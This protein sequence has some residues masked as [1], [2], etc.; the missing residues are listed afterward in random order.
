[1]VNPDNV[2]RPSP[3]PRD[4]RLAELETQ[5]RQREALIEQLQQR[6]A[7]LEQRL[8]EMERAA[9]RQATPFARK[10]RKENPKR[11]GRKAG[12]GRFTAR[13]RPTPDQVTE[14]K[15]QPLEACPRCGDPLTDRKEHEQFVVDIPE[16]QP[17]V[18]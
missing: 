5:L 10:R 2:L 6:L 15:E 8:A 17:R 9:K 7:E 16:V 3:D 4:V 18:T 13:S 14:T 11:P 12:Q 1:M